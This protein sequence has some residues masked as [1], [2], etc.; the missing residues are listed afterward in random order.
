MN[1]TRTA[2][3][4]SAAVVA[5]IAGY[6]SYWH[7]VAV[8][9]LAGERAEIA[10]IIPLSVDG[11]LVV[12]SIVMVDDRQQ[13]RRPRWSAR[14]AFLI[15][16]LATIGA[17]V[18]G[19][20]PTLLGRLIAGWPA[21]AL[22][23]VVEM[24]SRRGRWITEETPAPHAPAAAPTSPGMPALVVDS[25]EEIAYRQAAAVLRRTSKFPA[26]NVGE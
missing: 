14:V 9:S 23:L 5:G 4:T 7:Q 26:L 1:V 2:R 22:P 13:G 19:A 11:M 6:A 16:T 3:N 17:N 24:L 20:H 15:G 8:A 25:P 21:L 10:H 18:A 12:A